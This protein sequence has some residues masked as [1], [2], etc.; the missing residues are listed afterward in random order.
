ME[1][2][3][4]SETSVE[5]QRT[6]RHYIPQDWTLRN[7]RSDNLKSYLRQITQESEVKW[8]LRTTDR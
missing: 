5:F 2:A 7:D 4:S 6:T 1:A 3:Y 8:Q